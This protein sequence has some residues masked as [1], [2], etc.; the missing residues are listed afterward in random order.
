VRREAAADDGRLGE[1][2][3]RL[4]RIEAAEA[5]ARPPVGAGLPRHPINDHRDYPVFTFPFL[6]VLTPFAFEP[7]EFR[8]RSFGPFPSFTSARA[9]GVDPFR[10]PGP[11]RSGQACSIEQRL[12]TP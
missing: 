10:A 8:V 12:A 7:Q 5:P 1:L 9:A 3:D 2:E 4:A 11:C 6:P